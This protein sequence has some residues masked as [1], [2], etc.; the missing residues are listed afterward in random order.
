MVER[1]NWV[2]RP[3]S[4][5]AMLGTLTIGPLQA[6]LTLAEGARVIR[7]AL[8]EGIDFIETADSYRTY[9]YIRRHWSDGHSRW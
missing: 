1:R 8:E 2:A 6:N 7:T 5:P 4:F 3:G 9:D